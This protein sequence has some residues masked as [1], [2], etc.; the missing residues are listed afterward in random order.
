M[1]PLTIG[2]FMSTDTNKERQSKFKSKMYNDGFKR[3]YIWVKK[4]P[5]KKVIK[6]DKETFFKKLSQLISKFNHNEQSK[7]FALIINILESK[8]EVL[9]LREKEKKNKH[10]VEGGRKGRG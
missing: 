9:E 8:K 10:E 1:L 6:I 7:L 5:V 4:E 2:A 3:I